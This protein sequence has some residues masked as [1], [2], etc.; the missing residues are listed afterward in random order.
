MPDSNLVGVVATHDPVL[1][2]IETPAGPIEV[3]RLVGVDAAELDRIETWSVLSF[4]EELR[5]I[6]PLL[7]SPIQRGS[8]MDYPPFAE[9]LA[10]SYNSLEVRFGFRG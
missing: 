8:A 9:R 6:N 7:L 1:P 5:T 3:R 4:V 10:P 2:R